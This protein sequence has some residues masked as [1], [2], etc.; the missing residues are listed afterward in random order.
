LKA[1]AVRGKK[2]L[3]TADPDKV[4]KLAKFFADNFRNNADNSQLNKFGTSQYFLN[5]NAAGTLPTKNFQAGSIE[6]A[7]RIGHEALHFWLPLPLSITNS[8]S[9]LLFYSYL[10]SNPGYIKFS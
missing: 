10:I 5:C 8:H 1:I 6:G 9:L 2:K 7:E 4:K 3:E